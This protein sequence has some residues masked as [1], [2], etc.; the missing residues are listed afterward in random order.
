MYKK[1]TYKKHIKTYKSLM[2]NDSDR[3]IK[4]INNSK[5]ILLKNQIKN[6]Q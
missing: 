6:Y 5:N 2:K 3:K 4:T 1:I